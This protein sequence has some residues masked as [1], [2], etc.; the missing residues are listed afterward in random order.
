MLGDEQMVLSGPFWM[1]FFRARNASPLSNDS[2]VLQGM[3]T[4]RMG[5]VTDHQCVLRS[6]LGTSHPLM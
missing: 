5:N 1:L 3:D 2:E 6:L 4:A